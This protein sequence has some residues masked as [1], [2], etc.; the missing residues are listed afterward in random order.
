[1]KK[2]N[3]IVKKLSTSI[4]F[5]FDFAEYAAR[6][7]LLIG[8]I[9]YIIGLF[10]QSK[11]IEAYGLSVLI[12]AALF[13]IPALIADI[14]YNTKQINRHLERLDYMVYYGVYDKKSDSID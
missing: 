2:N 5:I 7:A 6:L 4:N 11:V 1:M 10:A 3:K 13:I 8:L 14:E 12:G 9:V